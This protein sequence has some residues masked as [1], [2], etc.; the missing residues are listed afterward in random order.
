M[1]SPAGL[2][3]RKVAVTHKEAP[4]WLSPVAQFPSN[5]ESQ[6]FYGQIC[7][8]KLFAVVRRNGLIE[9][10]IKLKEEAIIHQKGKHL[11]SIS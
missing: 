10:A 2:G 5:T 7:D 6:A 3:V 8:L 1:S 9:A 4:S 11:S